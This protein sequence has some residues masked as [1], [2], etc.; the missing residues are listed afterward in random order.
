M[1]HRLQE[2]GSPEHYSNMN[3]VEA[4]GRFAII[5]EE[6]ARGGFAMIFEWI[7]AECIC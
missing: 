1:S 5:Y 4:G 6:E 7:G 3:E 2:F